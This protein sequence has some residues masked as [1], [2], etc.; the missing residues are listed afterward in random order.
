MG[1]KIFEVGSRSVL[2]NGPEKKCLFFVL[3]IVTKYF[4]PFSRTVQSRK[5]A[6]GCKSFEVG[7]PRVLENGPE[8][9]CSHKIFLTILK[10]SNSKGVCGVLIICGRACERS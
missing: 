2:E 9:S 3:S 8:K 4:S 6:L 5:L 7:A 10:N 1:C